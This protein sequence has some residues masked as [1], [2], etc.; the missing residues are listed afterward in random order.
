MSK[1]VENVLNNKDAKATDYFELVNTYEYSDL[2]VHKDG[3]TI[4]SMSI[5]QFNE[6]CDGYEFSQ[7][8]STSHFTIEESDVES[9]TGKMLEGMDTCLIEIN[10]KDG[11]RVSVCIYHTDTNAKR[12]VR[13]RFYESDVFSL[14]D[15]LND[16]THKAMIVNIHDAFGMEVKLND[17]KNCSVVETEESY[18]MQIDSMTFQLVDDSCNEIY[19]KENS[20]CDTILIRPYGQPF[21]EISIF[22]S[23]K[24]SN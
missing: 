7:K 21:L 20:S 14:M 13:E 2:S 6:I 16:D 18:E 19:I 1:A 11:S 10:M 23:K 8:C 12:E 15:S 17:I 22:V 24:N 3:N 9:V 5:N 4:L